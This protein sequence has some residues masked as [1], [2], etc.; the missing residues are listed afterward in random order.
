MA[1]GLKMSAPI[2]LVENNNEQLMVNQQALRI[3]EKISQ[4]V[5]VVA[6]VGLC[7][8]GKSYLMNRLAGQNCSYVVLPFPCRLSFGL[9]RHLDV[10]CAPPHKGLGDVEKG[11]PKNDSWIFALAVLLSSTFVYNSM[12][13][14]NQQALDQLHYVREVTELIR[15]KSSS[16]P[17]E[18]EDGT[19]FVSFFPDFVW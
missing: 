12:G 16:D 17:D 1:S 7:R 4:P 19:E 10:V 18:I 5:I 15:A 3:L 14:I 9:H 13:T 8:T 2:C 11:D 6:I